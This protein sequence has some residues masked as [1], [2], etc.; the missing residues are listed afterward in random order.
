MSACLFELHTCPKTYDDDNCVL[1]CCCHLEHDQNK[2]RNIFICKTL[3]KLQLYNRILHRNKVEKEALDLRFNKVLRMASK[4]PS[5]TLDAQTDIS[6]TIVLSASYAS[7]S[8]SK[9]LFK[10][11]SRARPGHARICVFFLSSLF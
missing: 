8:F 9:F 10:S 11:V 2:A 7:S 3:T 4:K 6:V 5:Y 1:L